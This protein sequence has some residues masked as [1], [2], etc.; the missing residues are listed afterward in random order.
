MW[1][2]RAPRN[3]VGTVVL[4]EDAAIVAMTWRKASSH[5]IYGPCKNFRNQLP[6]MVPAAAAF[7]EIGL[8]YRKKG[9]AVAAYGV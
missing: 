9:Q 8:G 7:A 5:T 1:D 4:S 3:A 6:G 2:A